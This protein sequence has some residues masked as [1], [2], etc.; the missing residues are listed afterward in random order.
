MRKDKL[1]YFTI[2]N[3]E[4]YQGRRDK[5]NYPWFKFHSKMFYDA[6]FSILSMAGKLLFIGLLGLRNDQNNEIASLNTTHLSQTLAMRS[7]DFK[8]AFNEI[9]ELD[10]IELCVTNKNCVPEKRRKEKN[11]YSDD[12]FSKNTEAGKGD[13]NFKA[14]L[15][16]WSET[17][18]HFKISSIPF[19]SDIKLKRL[20][21]VYPHQELIDAIV[22]MRYEARNE[23]YNP[24]DNVSLYRLDK[25]N[26]FQK[27]RN[28]GNKHATIQHN[29]NTPADDDEGT[30]ESTKRRVAAM[31]PPSDEVSRYITTLRTQLALCS[32]GVG[33]DSTDCVDSSTTRTA[34]DSDNGRAS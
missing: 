3:W 5:N 13:E 21:L 11:I 33:K 9:V 4:I 18:S 25:A 24:G 22:G 23:K 27:L 31:A 6:K 10:M 19:G 14:L 12:N 2:P 7:R 17:C 8:R 1:I 28:L 34:E 15:D 16:A 30:L 26:V 32:D 20:S 29:S